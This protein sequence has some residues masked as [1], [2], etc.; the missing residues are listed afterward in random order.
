VV[1]SKDYVVIEGIKKDGAKLRPSDWI[2]RLSSTLA[3]FGADQRLR[4][5]TCVRPCIIE[6]KCCL[7][8]ARDLS[9][10]NPAAYDFIMAFAESNHLR[11]QLDRR[12]GERALHAE[13][14]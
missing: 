6:G 1:S 12:Q 2:E 5:D 8:V 11:I 9:D 3:S 14:V 4:Y 13:A 7:V 10:K